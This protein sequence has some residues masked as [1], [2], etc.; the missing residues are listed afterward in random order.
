MTQKTQE[1]RKKRQGEDCYS[2]KE[3][4]RMRKVVREIEESEKEDFKFNIV[5]ESR[6]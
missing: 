3:Y 4:K 1:I 6:I 5:V 2:K